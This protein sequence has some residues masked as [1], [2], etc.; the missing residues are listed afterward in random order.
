M[1]E[2]FRP[3]EMEENRSSLKKYGII[4]AILVLL[5]IISLLSLHSCSISKKDDVTTPSNVEDS[6]ALIPEEGGISG[7]EEDATKV[8]E[9]E[10][11][12]SQEVL[13]AEESE[14]DIPQSESSVESET[15]TEKENANV[16]SVEDDITGAGLLE[17]DEP[18]LGKLLETSVIV[19][20]KKVYKV[21]DN[22]YAFSVSLIFPSNGEYEVVEYFCSKKIYDGVVDG[23]TI[24]A[25]YQVD[26][27]GHVAITSISR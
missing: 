25:S 8:E 14:G 24:T 15:T 23:E 21:N 26:A 19:S 5:L 17:V 7:E 4:V 16:P 12:E 1:E 10:G 11:V 2:E 3:N 13:E 27:E 9:V 18:A 22:G 6:V 20:G